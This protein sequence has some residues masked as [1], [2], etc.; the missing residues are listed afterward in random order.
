VLN[1]FNPN[2]QH[3]VTS[4]LTAEQKNWL[5]AFL[6]QITWPETAPPGPVDAPEA[7]ASVARSSFDS[8]FP[9]PFRDETSLKFSLEKSP[10]DV[11]I[12]VFDVSGRRVRTLLQRTMTRG[13]HIVGWDARD[14][15]NQLVAPG[16][17]FAKL[18]L[19]D[20]EQMTKRLTILR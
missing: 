10:S 20:A 3:G 13:T 17:Y 12:D 7:P 6:L 16:V 11:R 18:S 2:D 1:E 4:G 19:G 8:A 9:N 14:D 15:S 5:V